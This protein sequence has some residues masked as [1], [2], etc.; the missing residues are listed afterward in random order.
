MKRCRKIMWIA[1]FAV[2]GA[3]SLTACG[4]R[5]AELSVVEDNPIFRSEGNCVIRRSDQGLVVGCQEGDSSDG[6]I[7]IGDG[8]FASCRLREVT[9]PEIVTRIGK[10]AF[11]NCYWLEKINFP[12]RLTE[13]GEMA[14]FRCVSLTEVCFPGGLQRL[15]REFFKSVINYNLS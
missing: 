6:V 15:E 14:F 9:M 3:L 5:R 10:T 1:V 7:S 13:I 11:W 8:A 4:T 12:S 2:I